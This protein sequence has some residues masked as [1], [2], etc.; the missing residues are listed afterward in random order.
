M[1]NFVLCQRSTFKNECYQM[2]RFYIVTYNVKN[3]KLK[4]KN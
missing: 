3:E 4:K 2:M 1:Q